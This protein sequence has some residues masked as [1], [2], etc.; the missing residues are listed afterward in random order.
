M[1]KRKRADNEV[2]PVHVKKENLSWTPQMDA[3]DNEVVYVPVKKENLSWTPKMDAALIEALLVEQDKGHRVGGTFLTLAYTNVHATMQAQFKDIT[4]TK[5]NIQNRMKTVKKKF[6]KCYDLFR[7]TALSGFSWN[8]C[9]KFIEAEPEVWDN[10]IRVSVDFK[11]YLLTYIYI[12]KLI[13]TYIIFSFV[14]V[15][16]N[17]NAA[18]WRAKKIEHYDDLVRLFG[19]DR[20]SGEHAETSKEKHA[21][22]S[23]STQIKVEKIT[24][25]DDLVAQ[26]EVTL[27][28]NYIDDDDEDLQILPPPSFAPE[29]SSS[30]KKL[31]N[32]RKKS[33]GKRAAED[34]FF[35][36]P[37]VLVEAEPQHVK[38]EDKLIQSFEK[39]AEGLQIGNIQ[40]LTGEDIESQLVQ[41]G[42]EADTDEFLD[43]FIYLSRNP[44]DARAIFS[45]S[46][47]MRKNYLKRMMDKAK[48]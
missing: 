17:P 19:E 28:N 11:L 7:G 36:D 40:E 14:Y 37:P 44:A 20:A 18:E 42:L 39:I 46:L 24:D 48:N 15:Q 13:N 33:T 34:D 16:A 21:R 45:S 31:R 43:A 5:D 23:N 3:A 6:S 22:L 27:E 26:K 29:G 41:M 2:V 12:Y 30:A 8:S 38:F 25:V 10:L 47:H 4:I 32:K 1:S 35:V 9:T